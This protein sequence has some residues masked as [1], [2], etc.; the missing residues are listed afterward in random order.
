MSPLPSLDCARLTGEYRLGSLANDRKG[1]RDRLATCHELEG[2]IAE[3]RAAIKKEPQFNRQVE[4]NTM[5]KEL[6]KEL[7]MKTAG[8]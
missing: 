7:K 4:L 6:E 2:R 3:Y 8:L 5:I 1:R